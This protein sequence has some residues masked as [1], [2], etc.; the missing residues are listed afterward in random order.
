MLDRRGNGNVRGGLG[1]LALVLSLAL[2]APGARTQDRPPQFEQSAPIPAPSSPQAGSGRESGHPGLFESI[3]RWLD[4]SARNF[5]DQWRS[6]ADRAA[7]NSREMTERAE[8]LSKN[9]AQ[10]TADAVDAVAKLP[11]ARV[12]D[13]RERCA[14][15]PNGAPDCRAAAE[16][17][18][19]RHGFASGKSVD[20]TSARECPA[21][22]LIGGQASEAECT[23]VTF[24]NR[25]M[26]Q[27]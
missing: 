1:A 24:I 14:V 10:A 7:A 5:H 2:P 26:C 4:R 11:A 17:L 21:R 3:G 9:A 16:A 8:E 25:A 15:A 23:T 18:C 6:A 22:A 13:G 27:Q 12:M 19:R 20:F